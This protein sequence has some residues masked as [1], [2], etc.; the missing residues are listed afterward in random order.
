ML[1][2]T[3][4]NILLHY[5]PKVLYVYIIMCITYSVTL[6]FYTYIIRSYSHTLYVLYVLCYTLFIG[7]Y[8]SIKSQH[9]KAI[10]YFKR[11]LKLNNKFL[12][13]YTLMGHEYLEL[14]NTAA[15]IESYR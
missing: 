3:F 2:Y 14:R 8:Y 15:A 7:N 11:A 9:D 4:Y 10:I 12:S 5:T 6:Y 1:H 13:A